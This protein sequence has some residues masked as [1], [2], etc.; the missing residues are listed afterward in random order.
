MF[1][2]YYGYLRISE[3]LNLTIDNIVIDSERLRLI[4]YILF[5]KTDQFGKGEKVFIYGNGLDFSLYKLF[6][7][8]S[9]H[10]ND[11]QNIVDLS[12]AAQK[13]HLKVILK[14]IGVD[15]KQ[16]SWHSFRKGGPYNATITGVDNI[17]VFDIAHH[18]YEEFQ[19]LYSTKENVMSLKEFDHVLPCYGGIVVESFNH[20]R[21]MLANKNIVWLFSWDVQTK[22][23]KMRD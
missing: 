23:K 6:I 3:L 15:N 11:H 21:S 12:P 4:V 14:R 17:I 19:S 13:Q 5:Q 9:N 2:S 18:R 20:C 1:I 22:R 7:L 16:Y 10:Y 8:L